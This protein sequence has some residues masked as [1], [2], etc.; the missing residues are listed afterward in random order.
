[1]RHGLYTEVGGTDSVGSLAARL[2]ALKPPRGDERVSDAGNELS[3]DSL[4]S[5]QI[6]GAIL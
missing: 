2:T 6:W 5:V 1:M 4:H 3:S